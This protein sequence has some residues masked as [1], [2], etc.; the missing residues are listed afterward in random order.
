MLHQ[1]QPDKAPDLLGGLIAIRKMH[2]RAMAESG[3]TAAD[4]NAVPGKP[5]L[6]GRPALL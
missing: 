6:Y 2:I 5:Q 3:L 1:P 4:E